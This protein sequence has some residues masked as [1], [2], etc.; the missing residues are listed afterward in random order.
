MADRQTRTVSA[1][2]AGERLD[3]LVMGLGTRSRGQVQRAIRS[4]K[5]AVDGETVTEPGVRPPAGAV[6]GIDW[7]R[8]GTSKRATSAR[9]RLSQARIQI[10]FEDDDLLVLDKPPGLLTDTATRKQARERDSLRKRAAGYLRAQGRRPTVVHRIDRDTSG[11]VLLAKDPEVG[12]RLRDAFAR[13]EP[14]RVYWCAVR[15]A[16]EAGEG[17]FEDWMRWDARGRRQR[18]ASPHERGAVKASARWRVLERRG[19]ITLLEVRLHTGRRNQIRLHCQLR[20]LPLV[21]ETQ[22]VDASSSA[23]AGSPGRQALHAWRLGLRH[24]RT[25]AP[26]RFEVPVP[27]ELAR[28]GA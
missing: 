21:G 25:G 24:P 11:L 7:S 12:Q 22:Y 20:G 5:V 8:P 1:A 14:E 10:V 27:R 2:D 28:L 9:S 17:V 18:S 4:G 23:S 3:K 19:R 6:V 13:H 16:P 15:G 26:V